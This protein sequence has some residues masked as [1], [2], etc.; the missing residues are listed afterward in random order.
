MAEIGTPPPVMLPARAYKF[1]LSPDTFDI[2]VPVRGEFPPGAGHDGT[3]DICPEPG[4]IMFG[5]LTAVL[6]GFSKYP[7]L[8]DSERLVIL[9]L[10][11]TED[12]ITVVCQLMSFLEE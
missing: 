2:T 6:F 8:S 11:V 7:D 1:T 5:T 10:N 3:Y 4:V 9:G 12:E